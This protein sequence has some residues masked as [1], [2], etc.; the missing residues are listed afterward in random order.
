MRARFEVLTGQRVIQRL[1]QYGVAKE[2]GLRGVVVDSQARVYRRQQ[3]LCP[4]DTGFMK[5]ATRNE[6]RED[7]L[8]Y[9]IGWQGDDFTAQGLP[10]YPPFQEFGTRLMDA[11]PSLLPALFEEEPIL[12]REVAQVM[13]G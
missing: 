1:R 11:Q 7:G 13:R 8:G 2:R 3:Q 6:T 9:A 12:R 4:V 10:F 5:G